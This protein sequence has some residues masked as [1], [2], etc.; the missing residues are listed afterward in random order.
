[1]KIICSGDDVLL[2]DMNPGDVVKVDGSFFLVS[3]V[4]NNGRITCSSLFG[5]WLVEFEE[6]I[7]VKPVKGEFVVKS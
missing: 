7:Y 4:V 2:K 6:N 3:N 1:M 5:G